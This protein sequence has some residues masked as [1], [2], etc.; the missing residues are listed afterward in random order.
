MGVRLE[1]RSIRADDGV[2]DFGW[3]PGVRDDKRTHARSFRRQNHV[4]NM[5]SS[6]LSDRFPADRREQ[7]ACRRRRRLTSCSAVAVADSPRASRPSEAPAPSG[8]VCNL[9]AT[10]G[11][12]APSPS[13]AKTHS[14]MPRGRGARDYASRA[15]RCA[16]ACRRSRIASRTSAEDARSRRRRTR[17]AWAQSRSLGERC[18]HASIIILYLG[19]P[20]LGA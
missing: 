5:R 16:E 13:R 6:A 12:A 9:A 4:L 18:F 1:P 11:T 10:A 2:G 19:G 7:G 20:R 14:A 8:A 15:R 17:W 3:R